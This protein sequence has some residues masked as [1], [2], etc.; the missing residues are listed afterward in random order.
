MERWQ[1]IESLFHQALE[2]QKP[3]RDSFLRHACGDDA[4]LFREVASLLANHSEDDHPEPWA[5][6][7]AA[8]LIMA[9]APLEAGHHL[10]PYRIVSFLAAGGMGAVYRAHDPRTS[11]D[12]A[13]KVV[14]QRF[15]ARFAREA[16]AIAALNH[17]NICTLYDVGP[18]YL[19]MELVE[20]ETPRG[21]LPLETALNYAMQIAAS[22]EAAHEKGIVHRDL[23]PGNIKI[24]PDGTV[25]VLDF[26]LAQTSCPPETG[27]NDS[28]TQTIGPT[29]PGMILGTVAYMSPEQARGKP[30]DT[31]AD[32]W[33][34][35]V[36]LY[37]LLTG[38]P[39]FQGED[40]AE[41]L[42]NVLKAQPD[43]GVAPVPARK[44]LEAC[45]QKDPKKRL[46]AIGDAR[47]LLSGEPAAAPASAASRFGVAGWI[48]AAVSI[49]AWALVS[50]VHFRETTGETATLRYTITAPDDARSLRG[51]AV[52][53]DGHKVAIAVT[54]NGKRQLWL[55]PLDAL[56]AQPMPGTDDASYPFWSPDGHQ[57]GFFAG[58]KL[59]K[60]AAGGGLAQSLCDADHGQGGSWNHQDV[61]VFSPSGKAGVAI[62]RVSASGGV[63][64]D[65]TKNSGES[66][67]P[68]FLPDGRHFLYLSRQGSRE[69]DGVYAGSLD[70]DGNRRV[71]ADFS[72]VIFAAG[73]LLF[74]RENTLVA[75][76]FDT[77]HTEINGEAVS[78]ASDVFAAP[79]IFYAPVTASETGT[80]IYA[81]GS[82]KAANE[83]VWYDR[84][85][86]RLGNVSL[87]GLVFEPAI[88]PDG[89]SVVFRRGLA[90][91]THLWRM[92]L[93]RGVEQPLT[94]SNAAAPFWSPNGDRVAFNSNR[95]GGV[96]NLY[97][98][99]ASGTGPEELLFANRN[100]KA[101]TQWS[102]D[103]RFL[104]YAE[105]DPN[106]KRDIWVLPLQ[107]G[108]ERK[109]LLFLRTEFNELFGQLS[110]DSH[111]M[112]YTS[113]ESGQREVYVRPFP[114]A[115]GKWKIS[116]AGG[117]Q[118]RW[119]GDGKE[120]FFVAADRRIMAAPVRSASAPKSSFEPGAPQPLFE[121]PLSRVVND[122]LFQY[123]VTAD[124]KRFLINTSAD[125]A[126]SSTILTVVVNWHP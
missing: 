53:P 125:G 28:P 80:L 69:H 97:Q 44:L 109:P 16:R 112:A 86:K 21:P 26:G 85:G 11:R 42:A 59:K 118:P 90:T 9:P 32:I 102:R 101:L 63:P 66:L 17:P 123:D 37:E 108:V 34:F 47:F 24:K 126:S 107:T 92:D 73:R 75:Q 95:G 22:L 77:T 2:R 19:V 15:S 51:F 106:T 104:V 89:R 98:K 18:D 105:I 78:V 1:Q 64:M 68:V 50:L 48:T 115:E 116:V 12:V 94:T 117:E 67:F 120:L 57:I 43:L 110:P 46:Q 55:R 52:S 13:I 72:S 113:D 91:E 20:G 6:A 87:P 40:Q 114:P 82:E 7:A 39:L 29:E 35:G 27:V 83:I 122:A 54:V 74:V 88:S 70:G 58:G 30:V 3:E 60:I 23:K 25:K 76:P 124:G 103:G 38:K 36:V 65:V 93:V 41:T 79:R 45:L 14:A 56:Q 111:W 5:P 84:A 119:R 10:G 62:R 71:L 99:S 33:A 121:A 31:R 49:I 96:V 81:S 4:E 8:K 61:I 100:S